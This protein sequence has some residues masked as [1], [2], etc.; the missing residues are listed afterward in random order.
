MLCICPPQRA[1]LVSFGSESLTSVEA[2]LSGSFRP[3][4]RNCKCEV[5]RCRF[6][7]PI[8]SNAFM[9]IVHLKISGIFTVNPWFLRSNLTRL[10][11]SFKRGSRESKG[12]WYTHV[13]NEKFLYRINK[14]LNTSRVW[15]TQNKIR[16]KKSDDLFFKTAKNLNRQREN[17]SAVFLNRNL[18]QSL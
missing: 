10:K 16:K 2:T 1:V 4:H 7:R 12:Y 11:I 17:N 15:K 13:F 5:W 9:L 14:D 18:R 8:N 3:S 6:I